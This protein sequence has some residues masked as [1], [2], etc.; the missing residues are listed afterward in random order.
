[1]RLVAAWVAAALLCGLSAAGRGDDPPKKAPAP[2]AASELQRFQGSWRLEAWVEG[3]EELTAADLQKRSVFFG[4]NI[5]IFRRDGKLY[6]GGTIK[7]DPSKT[8]A[9]VNLAVREGEGKDDVLL[10][11]YSLEG[12]TLKLCFDP[13][14]QTRPEDFKPE[15]KGGATLITLKKPKPPAAEAV[16]I[17]GKYR[18]EMVEAAGKVVVTDAYVERRGDAYNVTYKLDD[19]VLFIGTAIRRGDQLSMGWI[20]SGQVGVSVYKIEAGPKLVGEY[21][22]LGGIGAT[23][24]ET[25]TPWKRVD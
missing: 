18:S 1:M 14:G 2:T 24:K 13:Q 23:A 10:G 15:A 8:P 3:G 4:A 7:L 11:I 6:Q 19:K 16:D 5:F 20:S 17:V 25:L 22:I 21:T 9:A 12:D